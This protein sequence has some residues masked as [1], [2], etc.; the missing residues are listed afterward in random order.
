MSDICRRRFDAPEPLFPPEPDLCAH[1]LPVLDTRA[2]S[3]VRNRADFARSGHDGDNRFQGS[4]WNR[5]SGSG[6]GEKADSR[7]R[8]R[9]GLEPCYKT[10]VWVESKLRQ[11]T[12]FRTLHI[13]QQQRCS[14]LRRVAG[15]FIRWRSWRPE[16]ESVGQPGSPSFFCLQAL[17]RAKK[18]RKG[19]LNYHHRKQRKGKEGVFGLCATLPH[20]SGA[21]ERSF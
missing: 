10:W 5:F 2:D 4:N 8:N 17:S 14:R 15:I 21:K 11:R 7:I 18:E 12:E 19:W 3:R 6:H 9:T 20:T 1:D 16:S 13:A